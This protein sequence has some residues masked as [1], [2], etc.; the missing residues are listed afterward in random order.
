[1]TLALLNGYNVLAQLKGYKMKTNLDST[2]K[3]KAFTLVELLVVISIIALLMAI[4][5]PSL[6]RVR[7]QAQT[8]VGQSNLKQWGIFFSL[9]ASDNNSHLHTGWN[10]NTSQE[11]AWP[12]A[13][14]PYYWPD[15][16]SNPGTAN[17]NRAPKITL[18]PT[19]KK[20]MYDEIGGRG[21]GQQ[22]FCA[23]GPYCSPYQYKPWVMDGAAGGYGINGYASNPTTAYATV[24]YDSLTEDCWR[25]IDA[26]GAG[27]IPLFLDCWWFIG[28]PEHTD[29]APSIKHEMRWNTGTNEMWLFCLDRHNRGINGTFF[30]LSV[31]KIGLKELWKLKWH[32]NFDINAGP[33]PGEWGWME[34]YKDY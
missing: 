34:E 6:R 31:R 17:I 19:T 33:V 3:H 32:R 4:L 30:D 24:F 25:S 14:Q 9:Y 10:G 7:Q 20:Y 12:A 18:C 5:M 22:P 13:L 2:S 8:V 15:K 28:F 26:R 29:V 21:E 1:L 16:S 11:T 23:W 27:N